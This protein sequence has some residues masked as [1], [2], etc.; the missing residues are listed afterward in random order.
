MSDDN[1]TPLTSEVKDDGSQRYSGG[2]A[3]E[4]GS[5]RY[6]YSGSG[7]R[8]ATQTQNT[9]VSGR[10]AAETGD[11]SQ[12]YTG[13]AAHSDHDAARSRP[14]QGAGAGG[15][16]LSDAPGSDI[17]KRIRRLSFTAGT[18]QRKSSLQQGPS[19]RW[20]E[21]KEHF[22]RVAVT[23]V[24][25]EFTSPKLE[26]EYL[27]YRETRR[28]VTR[29]ARVQAL[30]V[31][32][33]L[34]LFNGLAYILLPAPYN[35]AAV[36]LGGNHSPAAAAAAKAETTATILEQG[37]A[38]GVT[39]PLMPVLILCG[40]IVLGAVSSGFLTSLANEAGQQWVV[41]IFSVCYIVGA[42]S[43]APATGR[44]LGNVVDTTWLLGSLCWV[45]T[46][47]MSMRLLLVVFAA[48]LVALII[49]IIVHPP[50]PATLIV[51]IESIVLTVVFCLSSTHI[52]STGCAT[53]SCGANSSLSTMHR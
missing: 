17:V 25:C 6:T 8:P 10:S 20:R 42:V 45:T 11:G 26:A 38:Q 2:G 46:V 13:D 23:S 15:R 37:G 28:A 50:D 47:A 16:R 9:N 48:S 34:F 21:I 41:A 40:V 1:S 12:R 36:T 14:S 29:R 30:F 52:R 7:I 19:K 31:A 51:L 4:Y 35:H 18:K 43:L 27:K 24:W 44:T 22:S 32:A 49:P 3:D 39:D 5:Q 33:L 53:A